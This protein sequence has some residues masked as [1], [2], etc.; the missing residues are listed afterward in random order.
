MFVVYSWFVMRGPMQNDGIDKQPDNLMELLKHNLVSS[1]NPLNTSRI[2]APVFFDFGCGYERS[3]E[4]M[5]L[6]Q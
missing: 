3:L 5:R 1:L 2:C 6:F 4:N